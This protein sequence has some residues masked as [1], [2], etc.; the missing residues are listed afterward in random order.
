MFFLGFSK[1]TDAMRPDQET[2]VPEVKTRILA[3]KFKIFISI[4]ISQDDD[5]EEII[6]EQSP[7]LKHIRAHGLDPISKNENSL[8]SSHQ[9]GEA[10][11]SEMP[12][13]STLHSCTTSSKP[14]L[15]KVSE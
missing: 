15:G 3:V 12:V 1:S 6:W 9:E 11:P 2:N 7:P 13:S 8:P 5:N 14:T 10:E 4:S